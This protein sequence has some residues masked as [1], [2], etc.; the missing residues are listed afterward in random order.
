MLGSPSALKL[1]FNSKFV[2]LLDKDADVVTDELAKHLI[3]HCAGRLAAHIVSELR[4]DHA[5]RTLNVAALMIVRQ[6]ILAAEAEVMKH[7]LP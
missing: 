3:D 7:L 5:E 2:C 6:E 4:F 1:H